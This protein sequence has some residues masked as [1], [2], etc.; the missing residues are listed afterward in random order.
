MKSLK[1]LS[2]IL[3]MIISGS[4]VYSQVKNSD[5]ISINGS[6]I[7][8]ETAILVE[9]KVK[10]QSIKKGP[11]SRYASELLGVVAPLNDKNLY[12]IEGIKLSTSNIGKDSGIAMRGKKQAAFF[13]N[14]DQVVTNDFK[15]RSINAPTVNGKSKSVKDM[16]QEAAKTIFTLRDRRFN[17]VT[18]ALGSRDNGAGMEAMI[19]EMSRIE[20]E[21]LELFLGK[22]EEE[23]LTYQYEIIPAVGITN[24]VVCRFS[25]SEGIS[26]GLNVSGSPLIL[27][28]NKEN[29]VVTEAITKADRRDAESIEKYIIPDIVLCKVMHED[30]LLLEKRVKV[31]QLGY[32]I[33]KAV[34]KKEN[35]EKK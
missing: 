22:I 2:F 23:Y 1:I 9:I 24:Y 5:H 12:T 14:G 26:N 3:L 17:L 4:S 11:Y 27:T 28:I 31:I 18:G 25:D 33:E 19:K 16:A 35:L 15:D 21:Y 29:K 6:Y 34:F 30:N 13:K 20:N 32:E 10:R 8:P 7:K